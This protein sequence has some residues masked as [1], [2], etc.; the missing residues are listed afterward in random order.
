MTELGCYCTNAEKLKNQS[1]ECFFIFNYD[2]LKQRQYF[3][4]SKPVLIRS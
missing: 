3:S 1:A 2:P 4:G